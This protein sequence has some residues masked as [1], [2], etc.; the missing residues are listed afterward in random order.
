MTIS[1]LLHRGSYNTAMTQIT[2]CSCV[3]IMIKTSQ[4]LLNIVI[5][6]KL[7]HRP[8]LSPHNKHNLTPEKQE[9]K[10]KPTKV[11][12]DAI[13]FNIHYLNTNLQISDFAFLYFSLLFLV[14]VVALACTEL[15]ERDMATSLSTFRRIFRYNTPFLKFIIPY[16]ITLVY[17][18]HLMMGAT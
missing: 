18:S 11:F 5:F 15:D 17:G 4:W 6:I 13:H 10:S 2:S 16:L 14:L 12:I 1:T 7:R 8:S 3:C 9:E